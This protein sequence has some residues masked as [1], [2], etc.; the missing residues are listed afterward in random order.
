MW[1]WPV[2]KN[3][4]SIHLEGLRKPAIPQSQQQVTQLSF[5][6]SIFYIVG[7]VFKL[8]YW[9]LIMLLFYSTN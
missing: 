9:L 3:S 4:P 5:E 2:I 6:V 1:S 8:I 7:F